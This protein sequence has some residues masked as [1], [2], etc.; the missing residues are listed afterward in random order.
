MMLLA[1]AA[2]RSSLLTAAVWLALKLFRIRN[3]HTRMAA[4]SG[5]LIASLAM[6]ALMRWVPAEALPVPADFYRGWDAQAVAP[7]PPL[8]AAADG[9]ATAIG[10]SWN[11]AIL[12]LYLTVASLLTVRLMLGLARSLRLLRLAARVAADWTEGHDVRL[13]ADLAMPVTIGRS[14][15]LPVD[16]LGWDAARRRAVLAHEASHAVRG[17]FY[18]LLL[19]ALNCS[20]FWFNPAAWWLDSALADLAEARSDAAALA[21]A[22]DRLSYARILIELAGQARRIPTGVAMARRSTVRRRVEAI[23]AGG[24]L[25]ARLTAG[26]LALVAAGM[27]P[28]ILT[29][30]GATTS[31]GSADLLVRQRMAD[32]ARPRT[33]IALAPEVL[34][35]FAGY[36]AISSAPELPLVVTVENGHLFAGLLGQPTSEIFPESDHEFFTRELPGQEEFRID[37]AGRVTSVVLHWNGSELPATRL[38]PA[39]ARKVQVALAGRIAANRPQ[40]DSEAALRGH[41]AQIQRGEIDDGSLAYGMAASIRAMLPQI[42]PDMVALGP[43]VAVA[44]EGVGPD[45]MDIYRVTHAHGARRW[46]I[47]LTSEGRIESMWFS[48]LT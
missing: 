18:I 11:T 13:S 28:A 35:K 41:I 46:R 21:V 10:L 14:I 20:L 37:P 5:V 19:A 43:V 8:P 38:D 1:E 23:L 45:G 31:P 24:A 26:R 44:F 6:P 22:A 32:Q 47:R 27:I 9:T 12:S 39:A 25:P 29:A 33:A 36:Y 30:A 7:T 40:P 3:P 42:R 17:D 4:W 34:A 48:P 16:F 15:L 2:L